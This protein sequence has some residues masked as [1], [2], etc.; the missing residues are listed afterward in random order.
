MKFSRIYINIYSRIGFFLYPCVYWYYLIADYI[1]I[2]ILG[3]FTKVAFQNKVD[4]K[5][6]FVSHT[7]YWLSV[8]FSYSFWDVSKYGSS[9]IKAGVRY[10]VNFSAL[11]R[12][13]WSKKLLPGFFLYAL[14]CFLIICNLL[15]CYYK[16]ILDSNHFIV[17]AYFNG[18]EHFEVCIFYVL[19]V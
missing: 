8:D 9:Y 5:E 10:Q 11:A 16:Y 1:D 7:R 13:L 4:H 12:M 18:L 15:S 14:E 6:Y 19:E 3:L 17:F 2:S